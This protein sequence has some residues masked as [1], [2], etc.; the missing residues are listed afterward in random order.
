[1]KTSTTK[2][3]L[4]V[5]VWL[6]FGLASLSPS[7]ASERIVS[8]ET[9]SA[10]IEY[11]GEMHA[12]YFWAEAGQGVV[13]EM[14]RLSGAID[15]RVQ[16]FDPNG[17][18]VAISGVSEID[19]P[20]ARI[21]DHQLNTSGIYT[22]FASDGSWN[23]D[24]GEYGL[25]FVLIPC[26]T[27]SPQAPNDGCIAS[28]ETKTGNIYPAGDT[29]AYCFYGQTGQGVVIEMSRIS[30]AIDPR[31]QL[32][33]PNGVRVAI[34]AVSEIDTPRARIED[35]QLN[36]SGI[37]T[38]VASDG[39]WNVDTGEYGLSLVVT[40]GTTTSPQ[41]YDG[42]DMTIGR[43]QSGTI[44][45]NGDTDSYAFYGHVGHGVVIEIGR[46]SGAMDPRIQLYDPNGVRVAISAVSE[47]DTPRARIEDYQ[48]RMSGIY[49]IVV[50]DGSWNVDTGEYGLSVD[51][52]PPSDPHGLY[53][54][55]P[56]PPDGNS[57]SLSDPNS[58]FSDVV[59]EKM[60]LPD[61]TVVERLRGAYFLSWW[62]VI[63]AT[64]YD[65]YFAD[66]P[67]MPLDKIVENVADPWVDM[68]ALEGNKVYYWQVVA[69]TP[70]GD[71]QGS[72]WWFAVE[73]CPYSLNISAIGQGSIEEP[74][75][76]FYEY[77]CGED[78]MVKAVADPDFE[79]VRWE[80][81]AVDANKVVPEYENP[82]ESKIWVTVDG[83][84]TLTAVFEEIVYN[85]PL[86][87]DPGWIMEG[88][89]EYGIPTGQGGEEYGNPDPTSGYT[90]SNVFGVN[91]DGDYDAEKRELY[92]L[93]AGPFNL[94]DYH[95]VNL[96]FAR[97]LN[98]DEP[99]YVT[100]SVDVSIDD[101]NWRTLWESETEITDS[102]W[103][104]VKLS[105]TDAL[106]YL[107]G[108]ESDGQ[109]AVYLRWTYQVVKERAYPC[110]G[111]N[112][113]DI[114]L[115]GKRQSKIQTTE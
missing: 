27:T 57:V 44:L 103:F 109:S 4:A 11:G 50:S 33:D 106:K 26:A 15:P 80:G 77:S 93:C 99:R 68:P 100:A 66:S 37:Y 34:S 81:T 108:D 45:P 25:S 96:R 16:L 13:V 63:N 5:V 10:T 18:R 43:A 35:C 75:A 41:D 6:T 24:I 49:T 21:E 104:P 19:T 95:D 20:R 56:L 14:S 105:M 29:D 65:V 7:M 94:S 113:D 84:Y 102:Q 51:L 54:Y 90:G 82:K 32:Y 2:S 59:I 101:K 73:P 55:G 23:V 1:M 38:I 8:G 52:A 53:P 47:I 88:Q 79:F 46:L 40:G 62:S 78:V 12:Y 85:F 30:G 58:Q 60:I 110:S 92:S 22:I 86:D 76:G 71:I 64:G 69:H 83:A 111:W 87:S 17:V 9:K 74:S 107:L 61:G 72:T 3:I 36:M 98:T 67:C 42:G 39:S 70:A 91:L 115:C 97:W 112:V 114:Q 28:G 31:V 48:L 89:W